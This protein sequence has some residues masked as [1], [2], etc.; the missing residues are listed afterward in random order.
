MARAKT[1]R[2][3]NSVSQPTTQT[4]VSSEHGNGNGSNGHTVDLE[5]EIRRRA[6]EL[7]EQRGRTPGYEGEDWAVA[8]REISARYS[9]QSA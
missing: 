7:Y 6:Y 9:H 1:A 5:S 4:V 8:E 3:G 2:S